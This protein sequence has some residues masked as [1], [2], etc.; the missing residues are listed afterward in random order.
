MIIIPAIDLKDGACVRLIQGSFRHVTVYSDNPV[1]MA[2]TW[3]E[4]G[5][6]RIH[7]VDLDGALAGSP[8]NQEVIRRIVKEV[9]APLQV[10][11]GI[12]DMKT[13]DTYVDMGVHWVILGTAA[14][15]NRGFVRD[16]CK[17]YEGKIILAIDASEGRAAV[18][19]WTE[20]TS[21][22]AIEIARSY[23]GYGLDAIVY[24]D[25]KR[26]GTKT[27]VNIEA[28]K[29]L[30]ESIAI[31]VIASGGV[32][33]I[34]DIERLTEIEHLGVRGVIIGKALYTGALSL[35]DAIRAGV[36]GQRTE[37][38]GQRTEDRGQRTEDRGQRSEVRGQRTDLPP[39][40]LKTQRSQRKNISN[41]SGTKAEGG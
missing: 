40:S 9:T 1:E 35:E 28:T 26:D 10:G 37:D 34:D 17:F 22:S 12:R 24:T 25:I 19:G 5:A 13:I 23:E 39:A 20:T 31:P 18:R 36:R 2:R 6:N 33:G 15:K 8:R 41:H 7:V 11:G 16:A 30:A 14:L 4:K 38:R 21:V 32:S 3:Q 27:G 29:N